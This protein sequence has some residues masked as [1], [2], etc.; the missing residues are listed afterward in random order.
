MPL[1]RDWFW[2][3][4]SLARQLPLITAA[5]TVLVIALSLT[6]TY[7]ALVRA[8]TDAVHARLKSLLKVLVE[9]RENGLKRH[10]ALIHQVA[11]N[12]SVVRMLTAPADPHPATEDSA[13]DNAL[14]TLISPADSGLPIELWT[15]DGRRVAHVGVGLRDDSIAALPPE[16]RSRLRQRAS[17]APSRPKTDST[18]QVGALYP[19]GN[20][21]YYW[22]D[23]PVMKDG[24]R[25]G[26]ILQ[27]RRLVSNPQTKQMIRDL[28]GEECTAYLRN[29]TDGFWSS[30]DGQPALSPVHRDSTDP[31]YL[32]KRAVGEPQIGSENPVSETPHIFALEAPKSTIVAAPRAT[33]RQLA[34]FSL[35][36]LIGGVAATWALSRQITHPLVELATASEAIG[37]GQ[38]GRRVETS[39]ATPDELRRLGVS[40]N[41]MAAEVE[42]SQ[43]ALAS[44]VD[45]AHA[46]SRQLE[47]ANEQLKQASKA[48]AEARDAA[49]EAN[50]AKSDFLAV[51]SHE[52]RTPL[53]AI[54]G[55][56]EIL[57]LG[58]HG[59][60]TPA[61]QDALTRIAR[62]QQTL[63]SVIN[64]VL[65]F[66]K[67]EAGV[68]K[69]SIT[70][71][72]LAPTLNAIEDF[73]SPQLRARKLTYAVRPCDA[74]VTV[75]ADAD[76]L[77]QIFINLLSNAVKYTP[78]E[79]RIEVRCEIAGNDVRVHVQDTGIGIA[80][81]RLEKV[82]EPFIQVGRA[83]N[84]PHEG[85]G[86][87]LSIS[88][89]LAIA[90]GGSLSVTSE[91]GKGSTFTLTLHRGRGP[92]QPG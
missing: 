79:G 11:T 3:R 36:L 8:R 66:A 12:A 45:E 89:D 1:T 33:L 60:V 83:L 26:A 72:P 87:G 70:D 42:A 65:N 17:D 76:K 24:H 35:L 50:R 78:K 90:M 7:D 16:F 9:S 64:D 84:R 91:L 41:R 81:D 13:V 25:L 30:L 39:G 69:Y 10:G 34:M 14:R 75:R 62:S 86:L 21:V 37:L 5:V 28:S 27:Q 38:Y 85:V 54:G 2:T 88:R 55:Y 31:G 57:Q 71:V 40:F 58:I 56:T 68:I 6:I 80:A 29:S 49:L 22:M 15:S 44:Q 32:A 18:V 73:V 74:N 51:M 47:L 48:A 4:W 46:T 52:L 20:R 92:S 63:L 61:Q 77:Q 23:A 53:N 67:L 19:S 59:P 82:F 43:R